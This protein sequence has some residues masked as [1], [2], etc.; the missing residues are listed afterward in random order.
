MSVIHL[1]LP[2]RQARPNGLGRAGRNKEYKKDTQRNAKDEIHN[3]S[4]FETASFILNKIHSWLLK[5]K[6]LW[7]A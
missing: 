6:T 1:T 5:R 2:R 4:T 3:I 7:R